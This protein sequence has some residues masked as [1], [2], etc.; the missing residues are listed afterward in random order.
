MKKRILFLLP[1]IGVKPIGGFK[2]IYE[3]ANRLVADGF[4]VGIVYPAYCLRIGQSPLVAFLRRGKSVWRYLLNLF[5]KGYSC[6]WFQIDPKVKELWVWSLAPKFVPEADAYI[7]SAVNTSVYLN[8]YKHIPNEH[9]FYFI[10]GFETWNGI[11]AEQVIETYRYPMRKIVIA[12]WLEEIVNK[13][14]EQCTVIP[15]GFD[16][17]YF[18]LTNDMKSRNKFIVCMLYHKAEVKGCTDGLEALNIVK[19]KFPALQVYMFGTP[20]RPKSLPEWYHYSQTPDK[21]THN[22]LYNE[23]AI[24]VGT[25]R[26]EGWGLTI[27]E[28]MICGCAVACTDTLGYREMVTP[29]VTGL[30]SSIEN[31]KALAANIIRLIDDDQLRYRIAETGNKSIQQFSIEKS[32]EKF[33]RSL[34]SVEETC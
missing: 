18:H 34:L 30:V 12:H 16:F 28:A 1:S 5:T 13:V 26:V 4:D 24:F 6:S 29:N 19:K 3:Y 11:T 27:G 17:N 25:S 21:D 10:Q 33:K 8:Q 22:R 31:P 2:V 15:D 9:K 20:L 14:G 23:A 7:A 32:Y